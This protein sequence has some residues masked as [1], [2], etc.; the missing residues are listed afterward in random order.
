MVLFIYREKG[1]D[2]NVPQNIAEIIVAK[3]RNGAVGTIDLLYR[4]QFTRFENAAVKIF[5]TE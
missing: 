5:R 2:E 4:P 3:H 1:M